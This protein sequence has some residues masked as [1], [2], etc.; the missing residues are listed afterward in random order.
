[1][2]RNEFIILSI[3]IILIEKFD[4]KPNFFLHKLQIVFFN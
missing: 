1:M 4:N 2:L 3:E